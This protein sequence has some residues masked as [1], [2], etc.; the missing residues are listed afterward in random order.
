MHKVSHG[1]H[2]Q[3]EEKGGD[4]NQK[5]RHLVVMFQRDLP[6][7]SHSNAL[8]SPAPALAAPLKS[9]GGRGGVPSATIIDWILW[10][11]S[12]RLSPL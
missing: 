7:S 5:D 11:E 12:Q 1:S 9:P 10:E 8:G 3:Q 6:L 4:K 2:G